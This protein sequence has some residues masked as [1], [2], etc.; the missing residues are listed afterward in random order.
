VQAMLRQELARGL[1]GWVAY[2]FMR[3]ERR[4]REGEPMVA[5]DYDQTHVL[6]A[7][8]AYQLPRGFDVS[9]RLRY[10]TGNPRTPVIGA[11]F[12][13]T[14]NLYQPIFGAHN[15]IRI[16]AFVQL[17]LRLAKQ[18]KIKGST[19][20]LFLEVLNVWNQKNKEEVVYAPDYQSFDYIR[21]FPVLPSFGLQWDF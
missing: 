21:S 4:Y 10:A 8:L 2:T 9:G 11:Y 17:D 18:F 20:D 14:R 7:V 16:P 19:L 15:S 3:A 13:A 1:F 6:T 5:S 12:D